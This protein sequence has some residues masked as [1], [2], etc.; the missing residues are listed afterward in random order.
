[1]EDAV[2]MHKIIFGAELQD[3][4]AGKAPTPQLSP[5]R[6]RRPPYLC[7]ATLSKRKRVDDAKPGHVP[8]EDDRRDYG[9]NCRYRHLCSVEIHVRTR[10]EQRGRKRRRDGEQAVR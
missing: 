1:M 9:R 2:K 4:Q 7:L 5:S 3:R 10:T 8:L 6:V